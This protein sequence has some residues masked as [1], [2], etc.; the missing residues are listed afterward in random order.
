MQA[1]HHKTLGDHAHAFIAIAKRHKVST[2][3]MM[4]AA[5][6]EQQ[7]SD[8]AEAAASELLKNFPAAKDIAWSALPAPPPASTWE[9]DNAKRVAKK[10]ADRDKTRKHAQEARD[11]RAAEV[12]AEVVATVEIPVVP[13][14][15]PGDTKTQRSAKKKASKRRK[16]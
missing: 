14:Q 3:A 11:L 10:V 15:D 1:S 5:C 6:T 16:S 7:G 12:S 4:A 2:D 9:A 8:A 13:A